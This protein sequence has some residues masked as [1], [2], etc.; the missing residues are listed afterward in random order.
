MSSP[1][2]VV[3]DTYSDMHPTTLQ[4]LKQDDGDVKTR[5]T[6]FVNDCGDIIKELNFEGFKKF[7]QITS[8]YAY[9]F[10]FTEQNHSLADCMT[11]M[12]RDYNEIKETNRLVGYY[13]NAMV[14][15]FLQRSLQLINANQEQIDNLD[16]KIIEN[17]NLFKENQE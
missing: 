3:P 11:I 14:F 4:E 16:T 5:I 8:Q 2:S 6:N 17:F 15:E 12:I 10:K 7:L 9:K 13:Y 1:R